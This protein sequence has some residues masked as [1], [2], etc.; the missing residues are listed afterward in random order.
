M[1]TSSGVRVFFLFMPFCNSLGGQ[2][3]GGGR[4]SVVT[5]VGHIGLLGREP[6]LSAFNGFFSVPTIIQMFR[7]DWR[8]VAP[9]VNFGV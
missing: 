8:S 7:E 6:K 5:W 9:F 3:E 4:V 1:F 2:K